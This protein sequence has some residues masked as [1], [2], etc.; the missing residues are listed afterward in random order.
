[1]RGGA[2]V[3]DPKAEKASL[4]LV[5]DLAESLNAERGPVD[6]KMVMKNLDGLRPPPSRQVMSR[7]N[8]ELL[9]ISV[10]NGFTT[11]QLACYV[12]DWMVAQRTG[13]HIKP[14]AVAAPPQSRSD[15]SSAVVLVPWKAG[16]TPFAAGHMLSTK[17]DLGG[18]QRRSPKDRLV[19]RL[20]RD[21]WEI[22]TL[23]DDEQVGQLQL[24]LPSVELSLLLD[25]SGF[26][27]AQSERSA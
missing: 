14:F 7:E 9:T 4:Q 16:V 25:D 21:C 24:I 23:E 8:Y 15:P 5:E 18:R 3:P 22:R 2:V 11:A 12:K 19:L 17:A 10:R 26:H 1:M 6:M 27:L 20:L 13:D